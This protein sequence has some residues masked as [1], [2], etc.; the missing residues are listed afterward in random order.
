MLVSDIELD[1]ITSF[2]RLNFS[3]TMGRAF[4]SGDFPFAL[5][6]KERKEAEPQLE[7]GPANLRAGWQRPL[8]SYD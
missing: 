3:S 1:P 8:L 2:S 7:S 4:H 5:T 6:L